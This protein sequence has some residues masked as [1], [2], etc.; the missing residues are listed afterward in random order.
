MGSA[1]AASM[2]SG[3]IADAPAALPRRLGLFSLFLMIVAFNAPIAAMAGFMQLSIG[4]GN[5]LG[6]PVS[7]FV[8]GIVLL[9]FS[10]GFVRMS[11]HIPNPGSFYSFIIAGS[12]R[13]AGLA[14]SFLALTAYMI[15]TAGAYPYMGIVITEFCENVLG[16]TVLNWQSWSLIALALITVVG[17]FRIDLSMRFLGALVCLE[18][19]MVALWEGAVLLRGGSDGYAL[20]V[21]TPEAFFSG[22]PGL[23]IL[24]AMLCMI[25]IEAGACFSAETRR[26]EVTVGRATMLAISFLAIF[27]GIGTWCYIIT[28][29]TSQ[30]IA[31][32]TADPVGSFFTGIRE[33]LGAVFV[34][35][36]SLILVTS[37]LAALA[38]VQGSAARYIFSLSREG[39]F[40]ASLGRV[41]PRLE[42]PY[43][44][45][46]TVAAIC[47]AILGTII[48][49]AGDDP[50]SAYA[51]LTGTGIYFLLPLMIGTCVSIVRFYL[52]N[53]ALEQSIWQCRVAPAV[54]GAILAGLFILT[55]LHLETIVGSSAMA[56]ASLLAAIVVP[57][58]GWMMAEWMRRRRP[59]SYARIGQTH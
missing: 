56:R 51:G 37:Q 42:S 44:A 36:A 5:G 13:S 16:R 22:S 33:Y 41:H 57:A 32:A 29:G 6:A 34:P 18:I 20:E 21:F 58:A 26:P 2:A 35:A 50:V 4:F 7:F 55:S 11:A 30:A 15:L 10:I 1:Q 53:R 24:F 28:Q 9:F 52:R 19:L 14:G 46:L 43:A 17:L 40:P 47:T 59:Q 25:G 12:G 31:Q 48:L 39:V 8:G 38:S 45:V 23:G 49:A 54:A 3:G 27:Y